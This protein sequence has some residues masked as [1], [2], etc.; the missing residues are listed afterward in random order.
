MRSVLIATLC[1]LG[2]FGMVLVGCKDETTSTSTTPAPAPSA[3]P[4]PSDP[5]TPAAPPTAAP[6]DD[7]MAAATAK[8]NELLQ[9]GMTYVKENKLDLA[10]KALTQL[11]GMKGQ[12][13]PEWAPRIEQLRTAIN[14]AKASGKIPGLGK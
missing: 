8:A 13:P 6:A 2:V 3:T 14:T 9:Q 7:A 5:A 4:A 12:L 11:E 1:V 10:E